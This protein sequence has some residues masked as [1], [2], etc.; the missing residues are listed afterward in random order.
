VAHEGL[1]ISLRDRFEQPD[2]DRTLTRCD[3][4]PETHKASD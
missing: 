2:N 4:S 1:R 3:S